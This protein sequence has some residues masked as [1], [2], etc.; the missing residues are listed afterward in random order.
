MR[1]R[2]NDWQVYPCR[3]NKSKFQTEYFTNLKIEFTDQIMRKREGET[4]RKR[5]AETDRETERERE[6]E[7]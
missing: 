1:E 3:K 7:R 2:G 4:G 5:E 6:R